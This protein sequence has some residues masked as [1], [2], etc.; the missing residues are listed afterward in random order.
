MVTVAK[1][2]RRRIVAPI[3]AGSSPVGHPNF[4]LWGLLGVEDL[5][6][7]SRVSARFIAASSLAKGDILKVW[8]KS[9]DWWTEM[10]RGVQLEVKDV[11]GDT[12]TVTHYGWAQGQWDMKLPPGQDTSKRFK[13]EG[14]PRFRRSLVVDKV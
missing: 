6:I 9:G 12:I 14:D 8:T 7:I 13:L 3:C 1:R 11:K 2:I 10:R 5:S 4:H